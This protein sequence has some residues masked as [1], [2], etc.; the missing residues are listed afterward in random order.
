VSIL[1]LLTL[2]VEKKALLNHIQEAET[3]ESYKGLE[4]ASFTLQII[5][6]DKIKTVGGSKNKKEMM[7]VIFLRLLSSY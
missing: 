6:K 7:V 5:L 3:T 2:S 1:L 4:K